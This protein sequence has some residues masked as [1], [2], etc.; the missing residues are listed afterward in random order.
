MWRFPGAMLTI[1]EE[2][3][4]S[5]H[6]HKDFLSMSLRKGVSFY[7]FR[8]P[9][10]VEV[11]YGASQY[12]RRGLHVGGFV[13]AP[14]DVESHGMSTILPDMD[15]DGIKSLK[16]LAFPFDDAAFPFPESSTPR[17]S[18][19]EAVGKI[20]AHHRE[21]GGKTVLSRVIVAE[22][23]L[24]DI[25][26]LF[27]S[28]CG[29]Y[30]DAAVFCFCT[31]ESGLWMGASPEMLLSS[32]DGSLHTVALAG[33]RLAGTEEAWDVKNIEEQELVVDFIM[34]VM[35][36]LAPEKGSTFTRVAGPVEH[37]CTEINADAA[38]VSDVSSLLR[39][40]S[41][42]PALCGSDR[43]ESM[44][45]ISECEGYARGHYGGFVG[46]YGEENS[47]GFYVNLRSLRIEGRRA[48][49]FIGGGITALSEPNDEWEETCR[50]SQSVLRAI[51]DSQPEI[52]SKF[53]N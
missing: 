29:L 11:I 16:D 46:L 43:G 12:P 45:L 18:H 25:D 9:G 42:T 47:F 6:M 41:P 32:S 23:C 3:R 49:V 48:A 13:V 24:I 15:Y 8:E 1:S 14:F 50:K 37:L 30:P 39:R 52:L 36:G 51:A 2:Y 34:S 35:E 38:M 4:F 22:D 31:P 33:T 40:L 7:A 17:T 21:H 10:S 20:S 53:D 44:R 5:G 27:R 28:L 26:A 19:S